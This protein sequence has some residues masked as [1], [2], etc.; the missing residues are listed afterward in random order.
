M[1]VRI[2]FPRKIR[3]AIIARAN[4]VCEA[5]TAVLKTGEGE[6]DH[7]LPCALGGKAEAANGWLLCRVCH[8][9]KTA[10]DIRSVRKADRARDKATRAM[11]SKVKIR[12]AGFPKAP[13]PAIDKLP[14][15]GPRQLFA[16]RTETP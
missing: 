1:T 14:M 7:I 12:S 6:V 11:R 8:G 3:A 4:G 10:N 16:E 2:E 15:L 13:K 9:E 5:C